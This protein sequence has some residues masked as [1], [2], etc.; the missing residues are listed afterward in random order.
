MAEQRPVP[1]GKK[2]FREA[3]KDGQLVFDGATGTMLQKLGLEPGGCPDELNISKPEIV[4]KVHTAYLDAGSDIFTTN[5]FGA[6]RPKLKEYDLEDKLREINIAGVKAAREA[7]G[8]KG[9]VAGGIGPT[10]HFIEP[11]G[12]LNFDAAVE[13]FAEQAQAL[14]DGGA[15]LLII[16]T[17]M[18]IKEMRAAI[19]GAKTTGLPV[20]ATMTFDQSMRTILGTTPE[21]WAIVASGLD[22]DALGANCSLGIEGLYEALSAMSA[23]TN[24]PLIAQPNAG[25]PVLVGKETVFPATPEEMT[26]YV[27]RLVAIGVRILGGCCGTTP[28]HIRQMGADFR[29][30]Q[31]EPRQ[32]KTFTALASRT[33]TTRFGGGLPPITIGER[34]NPTGRKKLAQ[35][36]KD[37]KTTTICKE[38]REQTEAGANVLD[39]NVGVPDIDE[40]AAM[41]RAVFA[42]NDNTS[43][44]IVVDSPNLDALEEGLKAVDGRPLINSVS[45]EEEKLAAVLPLAK[46]YGAAVLGLTIDDK[47][48]P[49]TAEGRFKVAEK[50][51]NRALEAGLNKEDLVIDCLAM[52]VSADPNGALT[53]LDAI[54][55]IKERLGLATTL[56]V[57][58]ISF[59]LPSRESVNSHFY[60][61]ALHAGLDSAIMNV[62]NQSM[63]DSYHASLVL[64][65]HDAKAKKYIGRF[66]DREPGGAGALVEEKTEPQT[67]QDK[68]IRAVVDGDTEHIL[69]FVEEALADGWEPLVVGNEGLI[70]GL[71]EVGRLFAANIYFLP[72]VISS[73]DTVKKAF[74]RLKKEMKDES[75]PKLGKVIMAT[76]KGDIHDIGKNIVCTLLEN[77]GFEVIDLGKNVPTEKIVEEARARKVDIVGLS[78]LMTTTVMEM[79][80]VVKELKDAGVPAAVMVGGAV[81][82][83]EFAD[84]IKAV[85]GGEA[86]AAVDK[87]KEIVGADSAKA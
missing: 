81:V 78:A 35:E 61:M 27:P 1:D 79:D 58:N 16:E 69:D 56:G 8:D 48:I 17:M 44:P 76:V 83:Q 7:I 57:S 15:D 39:V 65:A 87:M 75:G 33:A 9:Y 34:I 38:T 6:T 74:A 51:M 20:V 37:H 84:R 19:I 60:S 49:P 31:V 36:I 66:K 26:E 47:G 4:R 45:G 3:L 73:A 68:L 54:R 18:D 77:H 82:T 52:T 62:K 55:M 86:T 72:Q 70:L 67:I 42:V 10:G 21:V 64:L 11:V 13:I 25:I 24:T 12:D 2:T 41:K 80:N 46:K 71:N 53:T 23:V 43:L 85:F 59:G 28:E 30:L 14:K 40:A 29:S 32:P 22:V 5:T 63:M 50:I